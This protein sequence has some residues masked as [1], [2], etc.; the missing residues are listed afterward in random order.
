MTTCALWFS[1][2]LQIQGDDAGDGASERDGSFTGQRF[3]Q[4]L[5]AAGSGA[6]VDDVDLRERN[7]RQFL[8]IPKER[9]GW[10]KQ[11]NV[12]A[13]GAALAIQRG[14]KLIEAVG[15]GSRP[16]KG[17][18][19]RGGG[20]Q[21]RRVAL[22]P[23]LA[24]EMEGSAF[25]VQRILGEA[26]EGGEGHEEGRELRVIDDLEMER[27]LLRRVSAGDLQGQIHG[28]HGGRRTEFAGDRGEM[29]AGD[30]ADGA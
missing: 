4:H 1:P 29:V 26:A 20:R 2:D 28:N 3:A 15:A 17:G 16:R 25:A 8:V 14:D 19:A 30:G 24:G 23:N 5:D 27:L 10:R 9:G 12:E 22:Q 11:T 7:V 21:D 6:A 13:V 18:A